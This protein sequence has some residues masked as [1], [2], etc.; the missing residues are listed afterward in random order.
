[1]LSTQHHRPTTASL[2][3]VRDAVEG[4]LGDAELLPE[5]WH[6]RDVRRTGAS[7]VVLDIGPETDRGVLIEWHERGDAPIP[8]FLEGPRYAVAYRS[9]PNAW[10]LDDPETPAPLKSA[11]ARACELLALPP[12]DVD[13]SDRRDASG[14]GHR[15]MAF[16]PDRFRGWLNGLLPVGAELASGWHL[17]RVLPFEPGA[18][19]LLLRSASEPSLPAVQLDVRP[20][21]ANQPA[22][23]RTHSLD[24]FYRTPHGHRAD[25]SREALHAQLAHAL[26]LV[27]EAGEDGLRWVAAPGARALTP[28][29]RRSAVTIRCHETPRGG[30]EPRIADAIRDEMARAIVAGATALRLVGGDPLAHP[31]I[32][33]LLEDIRDGGVDALHVR[34]PATDL[35]DPKVAPQVLDALPGDACVEIPLHSADATRHDTAAGVPGNFDR[36]PAAA[37]ACRSRS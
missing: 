30:G 23:G 2:T 18:M 3:S 6:V 9:G 26:T 16:T 27:L 34:T 21:A 32:R 37:R 36:I 29:G 7:S 24:V 15:E 33:E 20:T 14:A 35:A 13:L 19:G 5:G 8:A 10:S 31:S 17:D 28:A 1:M 22:A 12:I 4:F 25:G 11:V